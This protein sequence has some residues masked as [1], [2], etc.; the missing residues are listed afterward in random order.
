MLKIKEI[1]AEKNLRYFI[2]VF[3]IYFS[4]QFLTALLANYFDPTLTDSPLKN[5]SLIGKFI[6][7]VIMAPIVETIIYQFA[8]IEIGF[9]LK[10]RPLLCILISSLAFGFSHW[11]NPVYVFVTTVVGFIFAYYYIGLRPQ[12]YTN[13]VVFVVLLHALSNLIAF[14][15]NEIFHFM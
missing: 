12:N 14:L 11:Y 3:V 7:I 9:R 2:I 1:P 6:L 5:E 13:R 15:N 10:L 8:I 4:F